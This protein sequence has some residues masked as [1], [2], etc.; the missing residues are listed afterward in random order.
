MHRW[1]PVVKPTALLCTVLLLAGC[2]GTR[3]IGAQVLG[4][5]MERYMEW[6]AAE[7]GSFETV[8]GPIHTFR[9]SINRTIVVET[10]AGL[11]V[12]DCFDRE[13]SRQL[14]AE[15]NRRF[16][17]TPVHAL[18]YSHYHLDHTRGGALLEPE[19]VIA[20]AKSPFYW[21]FLPAD[22][23]LAPTEFVEHDRTLAIG[24]IEIR[25]L[26]HGLG[27]T[28]TLYSFH[29]PRYRVLF[30]ADLAFVKR[31][32]PFGFPDTFMP[33]HLAALER[34]SELEFDHYVPSHFDTG[35]RD[36]MLEYV[37]FVRRS[38]ELARESLSADGL[39]SGAGFTPARARDAYRTFYDHLRSEFPDFRGFEDMSLPWITRHWSGY[40][41]G[42]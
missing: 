30:G 26:H 34:M 37:R 12:I 14:K 3:F 23:V 20:H 33:G 21:S 42:Y 7:Q 5:A 38:M 10:E 41:L 35:T 13:F 22:E 2:D 6:G 24:G 27:H 1:H 28:D 29:F 19:R 17:G 39:G 25:M 36:D 18:I 15:L 16:P 9:H 11:V 40:Y 4:Q 32:P 8:T 31:L